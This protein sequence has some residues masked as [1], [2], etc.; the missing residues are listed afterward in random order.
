MNRVAHVNA[1]CQRHNTT[2]DKQGPE[3]SKRE[4]ESGRN[5]VREG[6]GEVAGVD[7]KET[8]Q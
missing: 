3:K 8:V 2:S 6:E 4:R 7:T 1:A 5:G